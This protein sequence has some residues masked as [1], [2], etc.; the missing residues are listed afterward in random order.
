MLACYTVA[1]S[2]P[3][4]RLSIDSPD[5]TNFTFDELEY[6]VDL[7]TFLGSVASA[8]FGQNNS[9]DEVFDDLQALL[10]NIADYA[11]N[12]TAG[13]TPT[14]LSGLFDIIND[15]KDFADGLVEF[16]E[17]VESGENYASHLCTPCCTF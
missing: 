13:D 15:A 2:P 9:L 14:D 16:V 12:M 10:G 5:L 11:P 3:L 4:H 6:S 1:P 8:A 7:G 17:I